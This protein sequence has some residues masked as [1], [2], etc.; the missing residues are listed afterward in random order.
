MN[1]TFTA[2]KSTAAFHAQAV[3]SFGTA[4]TAVSLGVLY[5]DTTIWVRAF[6]GL[7]VLYLVTSTF[8]L[9]KVIRDNE[10]RTAVASR[11]DQARVDRILTEH[12]PFKEPA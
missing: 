1:N 6:L 10:E 8:T 2:G 11:V 7:G 9:A 12:D 4:L 5:L 3:I